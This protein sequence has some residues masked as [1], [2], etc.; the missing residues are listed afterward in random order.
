MDK[1]VRKFLI[2]TIYLFNERVIFDKLI[3][4]YSDIIL[5]I[6]NNKTI[7]DFNNVANM[8][9]MLLF[10]IILLLYVVVLT[11]IL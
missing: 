3:R 7:Y 9:L 2:H 4:I 10:V 6:S 5:F 11:H 8:L 1:F